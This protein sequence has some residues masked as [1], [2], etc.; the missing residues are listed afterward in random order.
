MGGAEELL[1]LRLTEEDGIKPDLT[2]FFLP[3]EKGLERSGG[4]QK[5][6][7]NECFNFNL[8]GQATQ[9]WLD[10]WLDG[11]PLIE[12][13]LVPISEEEAN[14]HVAHFVT[15]ALGSFGE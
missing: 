10:T 2:F 7:W 11:V 8:N 14:Q 13:A 4:A 15:L 3:A 5:G 9:F 1:A 6:P 12:S